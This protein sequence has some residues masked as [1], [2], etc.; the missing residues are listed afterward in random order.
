MLDMRSIKIDYSDVMMSGYGRI[1]L[2]LEEARRPGRRLFFGERK[3]SQSQ[4]L[5]WNRKPPPGPTNRWAVRVAVFGAKQRQSAYVL[6]LPFSL[7]F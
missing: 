6:L 4:K 7:L 3:A 5:F 2:P 1:P